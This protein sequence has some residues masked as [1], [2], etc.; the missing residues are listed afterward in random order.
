[1]L[2]RAAKSPATKIAASE[3]AGMVA[4][5][6]WLDFGGSVNQPDAFEYKA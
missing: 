1:M 2:L 5:G 3:A 4:S 6:M